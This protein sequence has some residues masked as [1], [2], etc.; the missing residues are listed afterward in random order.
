MRG[1]VDGHPVVVEALSRTYRTTT[2]LVRRKRLTIPA[3][4]DV[5]LTIESGEILGLVGPNGAGKTTLIKILTTLLTP[6]SGSAR[7]LG[8]DVVTQPREIRRRINFVFGGERG[9]YWRLSA[10]DNLRYF[11]DLYE[12]PLEVSRRRVPELLALVGLGD[13]ADERVEGFSKGM[14]QRL[15]LAKSLVNDPQILFLDEPSVG[16][17]PVAARQLRM[18]VQRIRGEVGTTVLLTSHYMW[19]VESLSDRVA[20][21][22]DGRIRQLDTPQA[23]RTTAVGSHVVELVLS[24]EADAADVSVLAGRFGTV[25]ATTG[26]GRR[27]L[28]VH[29]STPADLDRC[30]A[31]GEIPGIA[32]HVV[33]DSQLEDA[34]VLM[35]GEEEWS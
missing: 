29:T 20:V 14:K 22:V 18:L 17:D 13:R 7:V 10:A 9:L 11:A 4:S 32:A 23:L 28:Q 25:V 6:T 26:S 12:V 31:A 34:Y 33:R 1:S 16:L 5:S 30:V 24:D 21:L 27:M 2:G 8:Y 19:E 35:V 15:H 3:L